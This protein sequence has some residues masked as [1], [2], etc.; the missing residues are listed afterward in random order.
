MAL[1][2]N[3]SIGQVMG[4][5][6]N[7]VLTD[8][9][10]GSDVTI[11]GRRIYLYTDAGTTLVPTGITTA[12]NDW[13]LADTTITIVNVLPK[14]YSINAN[15]RWVDVDGNTVV[16]KTIL[17]NFNMYNQLYNY[18]LVSQEANGLA[19]LNV[20]NWLNYRMSLYLALNDSDTSIIDMSSITNGQTA[21]DRGTYLRENPN[22]S[23]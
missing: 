1:T 11:V 2:P 23:R 5:P 19:S 17:T 22:L 10:T 15:V 9:S 8:T 4:V 14:D 20:A 18:S 16:E 12:Y 3:F 13:P 6:A 21:N 7:V